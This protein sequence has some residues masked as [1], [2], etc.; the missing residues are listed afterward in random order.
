MTENDPTGSETGDGEEQL[1]SAT[2]KNR[3][4]RFS[5][6]EWEEVKQAVRIHGITPAEFVRDRILNLIRSPKTA[7]STATPA[8]LGPLIERTFRYSYMVATKMR[9]DM[10]NNG[11]GKD[12]ERLVEEARK[13]QDT[14]QSGT[15]E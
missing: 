9:D 6:T 2:R 1:Q 10:I 15:P 13:L 5:G 3:G 14:L 4:I 11:E 8:N 7:S 12:L